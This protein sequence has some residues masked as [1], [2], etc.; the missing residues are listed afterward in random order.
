[1]SGRHARETRIIKER[2]RRLGFQWVV[3]RVPPA[4]QFKMQRELEKRWAY[5]DDQGRPYVE[6]RMTGKRGFW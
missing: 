6:P 2:E 1:M 5:L 4:Q 3:R